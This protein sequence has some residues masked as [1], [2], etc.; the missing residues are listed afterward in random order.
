[1]PIVEPILEVSIAELEKLAT[2]FIRPL[3]K[4]D[5]NQFLPSEQYLLFVKSFCVFSHALFEGA[6]EKLSQEV[7]NYSIEKF[8]AT[9]G[10]CIDR[11]IPALICFY[12]K[13]PPA[14]PEKDTDKGDP[15]TFDLLRV[16]LEDIKGR[17]SRAIHENHGVSKLY[18]RKLLLPVGVDIPKSDEFHDALLRLARWRGDFAHGKKVIKLPSH[19]EVE[20]DVNTITDELRVM[21]RNVDSRLS[22]L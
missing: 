5:G 21:F 6:V 7:S 20:I 11:S 13:E 18:L 14:L 4:G 16:K 1:M 10:Q 9:S 2:N 17:H 22:L 15:T 3:D 8:I 19:T 12:T